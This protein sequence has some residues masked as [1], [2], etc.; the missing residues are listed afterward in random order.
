MTNRKLRILP[1][2][3][4][5]AVFFVNTAEAEILQDKEDAVSQSLNR[6]SAVIKALKE[7]SG[8]YKN[9][10]AFSK[11]TSTKESFY[12]ILQRLRLEFK[13]KITEQ[14]QLDLVYDHE[15]LLNDFSG[16]SDFSL[17]RQKNQ[18]NLNFFDADRVISDTEH[19][20]ERHLLYRAYLKYETPN[21]RWTFGKQ[22][23]DWGRMRFYS[24]LDIFNPPLPSDIESDERNGFDALNIEL[25]NDEFCNVNAIYGPGRDD[26]KDS[27]GL[28]LQKT[29]NTYDVSL[30]A[31]KHGKEKIAGFGFDGYLFDASLRGEFTY[32][33]NST[34]RYPRA[35]LGI[36]LG[37][38]K[39][40][41]VVMEYFYNGAANSDYSAF[42]SSILESTKRLSLKKQ[43]LSLLFSRELTPL[44]KFRLSGIYDVA[45]KSLFLNPE[46]RY[47][48]FENF[49][50]AAGSQLF[51]ESKGSEFE[52]YN[53]LYYIEAKLFF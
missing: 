26:I 42:S 28:K 46:F 5:C 18:K 25:F 43:L 17:I 7:I 13:P 22:L 38:G 35:A 19:A 27:I 50:V 47:N 3:L 10:A 23:I 11:T 40:T 24:P 31:L 32:T 1:V 37:I 20:Y 39:K 41:N 15:L 12:Y 6:Q 52:D 4:L 9:L 14:L 2:F 30:V 33:D 21:S 45:G 8:Y 29:I 44:L 34:D 36:D 49:D 16:T 53:N 51:S 48:I